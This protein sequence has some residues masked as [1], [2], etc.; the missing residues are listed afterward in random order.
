VDAIGPSVEVTVCLAEQTP[1]ANVP[2]RPTASLALAKLTGIDLEEYL[3]YV[4]PHIADHA[5]NRI[6]ELAR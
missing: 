2:R 6:G 4:L 3:S 5:I 1:V